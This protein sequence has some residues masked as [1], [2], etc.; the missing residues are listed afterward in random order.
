MKRTR[1]LVCIWQVWNFVVYG[2]SFCIGNVP[3]KS[4]SGWTGAGG[5]SP[6]GGGAEGG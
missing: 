2:S 4:P 3:R 5:L 1:H 6:A